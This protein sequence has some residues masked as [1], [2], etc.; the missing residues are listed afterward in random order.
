MEIPKKM[1]IEL[2]YDPAIPLLGVHTEETRIETDTCTPVF[3]TAL[4]TIARTWK[5][6]RY[7]LADERIL[8]LWYI[9]VMEYYSPIK[10]S[11]FESVLMRWMKLE[12]ITQS[13]VSQKEKHQYSILM[14]IYGI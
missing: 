9:Y 12:P 14:H 13:K 1:E 10:K 5:Q 11:A 3:I 2:P 6:P 8:K 4:F 7:P